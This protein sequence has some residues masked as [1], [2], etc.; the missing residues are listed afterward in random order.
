MRLRIQ[1]QK[2]TQKAK[3]TKIINEYADLLT[4]IRKEY[5]ELY[6]EHQKLKMTNQQLEKQQPINLKKTN[7]KQFKK[8][9]KKVKEGIRNIIMSLAVKAKIKKYTFQKKKKKE[10]KKVYYDDVHRGINDDYPYYELSSPTENDNEDDNKDD[11]DDDDDDGGD[12]NLKIKMEKFKNQF[13]NKQ[14]TERRN[15][16]KKLTQNQ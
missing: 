3:K 5:E 1:Y 9:P 15:F 4:R 10:T 7:N 6:K 14:K 2:C 13:K 12:F 8:L 11:D 16:Q